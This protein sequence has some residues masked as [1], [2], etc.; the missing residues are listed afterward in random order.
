MGL[1]HGLRP[2]PLNDGR[3]SERALE[4]CR[5]TRR[6]L[7]SL[8]MT[9]LTELSLA[10]G[11]RA[12]VVGLSASGDIWIVEVK[13]SLED[14]NTDQKWP[15]YL[16]WCDRFMFAVSPSFPRDVL[17]EDV[18]LVIADSYGAEMMREGPETRL[19]AARRK[20]VTLRFA[21]AAAGRLHQLWDPDGRLEL[22]G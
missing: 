18:G 16:S 13:S 14:F 17:P 5:G 1:V 9:T 10:D 3:Q 15:D 11:R 21:H 7:A 8:G 20:A 12:D 4:I 2:S 19:A 22:L 6:L